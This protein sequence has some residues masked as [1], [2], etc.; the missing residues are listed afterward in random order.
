MRVVAVVA[1]ALA[2]LGLEAPAQAASE[3]AWTSL[4]SISTRG[5]EGND[6]SYRPAIS[7]YGR[8]VAFTSWSSN[9]VP[10]DT[11]LVSDV[12]VRD[13]ANGITARLSLS[14]GGVQA[15]SPSGLLS[16]PAMSADGRYVA[17]TSRSDLRTCAQVCPDI[18]N[19]DSWVYVRDRDTDA[20]GVFDEPDAVSTT[21]VSAS[22]DG[23]PAD[24][25]AEGPAISSDGRV[26]AFASAASNLVAFETNDQAK[27]FVAD[28][29]DPL[30]PTMELVSVDTE[31]K[32]AYGAAENPSLSSDGGQVVFTSNAPLSVLDT[33]L[34]DDVYM[35]DRNSGITSRVS[36][37]TSGRQG[38]NQSYDGV[39]SGNGRY[40]V[41]TS[42]AFNLI[43]GSFVVAPGPDGSD[44]PCTVP[45]VQRRL[46]GDTNQTPDVFVRDLI[47]GTT[48]RV[49]LDYLGREVRAP[50]G[51]PSIS[52]DGRYV[53]FSSKGAFVPTDFNQV[54]DVYV[55]DLV[56][57]TI[58][59][60]SIS[61]NGVEGNFQSGVPFV[62]SRSDGIP[63]CGTA[64]ISGDGRMVVFE[65]E[66]STLLDRDRL[67]VARKHVYARDRG[68]CEAAF[69]PLIFK[70][71]FVPQGL[72]SAR[73]RDYV[74]PAAG[75]QGAT[76][77]EAT[78]LVQPHGF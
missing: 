72:V 70:S 33:N 4:V 34:V 68:G 67:P 46:C 62:C 37:S 55:R 41:F 61:T 74:E 64:L 76:V 47:R 53:T 71:P 17:F 23:E 15:A 66:A 58:S 5:T 50:S 73:L 9:L 44:V 56:A 45:D 8:F 13:L 63:S 69:P 57:E 51:H 2:L 25:S 10:D 52:D 19:D 36:E 65:S 11:N 14:T 28:R 12:F 24:S 38:A 16:A 60:V 49:S 35:H 31:G 21:L 20:D 59:R 39:I 78:C 40:V 48:V 22:V 26:I 29:T 18:G 75:A 27:I 30:N 77:H 1:T 54:S 6:P 43:P 7:A 3:P 42:E 32:Q